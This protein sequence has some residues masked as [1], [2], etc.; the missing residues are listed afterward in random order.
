MFIYIVYKHMYLFID[1]YVNIY[2]SVIYIGLPRLST[3]NY[4]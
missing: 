2:A 1:T 3:S 4:I